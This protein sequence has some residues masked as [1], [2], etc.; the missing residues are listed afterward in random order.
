[1]NKIR[2]FAPLFSAML[3]VSFSCSKSGEDI[4]DPDTTDPLKVEK[5]YVKSIMNDYYFW[6][7]EV[8][9]N[10]V[11]ASY[12]DVES[13]FY[14]FL[15]DEDHWSWMMTGKEYLEMQTGVYETYGFNLKQAIEIYDDYGVRVSYVYPGSPMAEQGVTRGF[16]L[17][18]LNGTAVETID[19]KTFN[20]VLSNSANSFTFLNLEG[21]SVTFTTSAREIQTV[22]VLKNEVIT[23]AMYPG[24]PHN[25]GYMVYMSFTES[26]QDE[27]DAAFSALAGVGDLVL[28][29][30]YNGGG[31]MAVLE[32]MAG[33]L[34]PASANNRV[35]YKTVHNDRYRSWN[36]S[37]SISR[38]AQALN[39]SRL[40]VLTSDGTASA[41]EVI[42][43]GMNPLFPGGVFCI[44]DTTYGK[45]NGM[46]VLPYPK[47]NYKNPDYVYLPICFFNENENGEGNYTNGL[48][49]DSNR[50]DDL[51]HNF[52]VEEDNL[53]A[54]LYYIAHGSFP[55]VPRPSVSFKSQP[56]AILKQEAPRGGFYT[57]LPEGF[58]L[59]E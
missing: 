19:N 34:A 1:M 5:A 15:V 36:A 46:Y 23:P 2:Y 6:Y 51:F 25:V 50:G 53:K 31:D 43:N 12:D 52:G 49:P 24:L 37:H 29:L 54:A 47:N 11:A 56:G 48:I 10:L 27:L 9:Q 35:L 30:R 44:G 40:F 21:Q 4:P 59:S 8:P 45:P 3:A 57:M 16:E 20:E 42:I 7:S 28:D 26:M 39:L 38:N 33:Y 22:S 13:Y 41:S 17:T 18:H 55:A 14:D 58:S 32:Y